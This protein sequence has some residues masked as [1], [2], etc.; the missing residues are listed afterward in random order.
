MKQINSNNT[1]KPQQ[2]KTSSKQKPPQNSWEKA[3]PYSTKPYW[4][5]STGS[6]WMRQS[7]KYMKSYSTV[8]VKPNSITGLSTP[9]LNP[10][11]HSKVWE[12]GEPEIYMQQ[13]F[14]MSQKYHQ[15]ITQA[16]AHRTKKEEMKGNICSVWSI[17]KG[18]YGKDVSK[19][20]E[21]G[22]NRDRRWKT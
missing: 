21:L 4:I 8:H 16:F 20:F 14:L 15:A 13:S 11:R 22:S 12:R 6:R 2:N 1:K 17:L 10:E 3:S 18:I 5:F 7:P 9:E 19:L